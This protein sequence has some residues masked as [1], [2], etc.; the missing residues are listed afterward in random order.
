[1]KIVLSPDSFKGSLSA[2]EVC[3]HIE[4]GIKRVFPQAEVVKLPVADGGEGLVE[5]MTSATGGRIKKIKAKDPLGRDIEAAYG[6]LGNSNTAVIEMAAASGLP[7]L[8]KEEQDPLKTST[9]GT[10]QL[11]QAALDENAEKII[12][13][14]GGSA[15]VDGGTGMAAALGARFLDAEGNEISPCGGELDK[16]DRIDVSDMDPRLKNIQIEVACDVDNPLTGDTGAARIYAP[17]KGATPD[18]VE[19]LESNLAKLAE[20]IRQD[21]GIDVEKEPGAGAAGGLGAGLLAFTGGRLASGIEIALDNIDFDANVKDSDLVIT[22][23]GRIDH[24]TVFGKVPVGVSMRAEKYNV[25]VIAIGGGLE[26]RMEELHARNIAAYFSTM[27]SIQPEEEVFARS[28]ELI[29]NCAE[30]IMR[31]LKLGKDMTT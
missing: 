18:M 9:F 26:G 24:Q 15:T 17:Q 23:E 16:L 20:H 3:S 31:V 13:G 19:I 4:E 28:D 22:G 7:L 10:G 29:A 2:I 5:V 30:Q 6:M 8:K 27:D 12:V 14:I 1:M 21:I 25:P 11:I